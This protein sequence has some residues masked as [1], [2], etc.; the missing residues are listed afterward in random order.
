[1]EYY[2]HSKNESGVR[3]LLADHLRAVAELTAEFAKPLG[4]EQAGYYLGLWHDIGKFDPEWQRYLLDCEA[5]PERKGHGPDHKFAG[6]RLAMDAELPP[7]ALLIAGHHGGLRTRVDMDTGLR[8]KGALPGATAARGLAEEVLAELVPSQAPTFPALRD[9]LSAEFFM[10]FLYSA[11]VDADSLDTEGHGSP[12]RSA[13]R[14]SR[15]SLADLWRRFEGN[16][17]AMLERAHETPVN[18]VRREVYEACVQAA[19]GGPGT[20]SLSVPTGGGKT[21]AGMGF[22]LRHALEN[23]QKRVIVAVPYLS[24]TEQTVDEYRKIFEDEGGPDPVV[25]EHHSAVRPGGDDEDF[26][27]TETWRRLAAENWDA[28]IVVTTTVQLFES[29]FANRRTPTRKLHRLANSVVILDEAQALPVGLLTPILDALKQLGTH[30]TTTVI[31]TATQPAFS[32]LPVFSGVGVTEIVPRSERYFETLKRV[33]YDWRD[34]PLTWEQTAELMMRSSQAL[35]VVNTRKDALALLDALGDEDALYLSTHLCGAHRRNVIAEIRRRLRDEEACRLVSTQVIE[36]GVDLD[37]PLVLRAMAPLD[38]I[39]QAA[40]RCNREGLLTDL[41]GNPTRGQVIVFVPV[42]GG[43]PPS[44][45]YKT[46]TGRTAAMQAEGG[47]DPNSPASVRTYFERLYDVV[48]TDSKKV[49]EARVAMNYPETARRFRMI[50]EDTEAVVITEYGT[51][52]EQWDV[53]R[54]LNRLRTG[55]RSARLLV[56]QLQPYM[57]SVRRNQAE[58]FRRQGL[59]ASVMEGLGEWTGKYDPAC[60]IARGGGAVMVV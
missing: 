38:S 1:M 17:K 4:A 7:I 25:L 41:E 13:L 37:F 5:R 8:E 34:G 45:S 31:S 33:D 11:L 39:I 44:G 43:L 28:P 57:V 2:A 23:G 59:I 21:R 47:L 15:V 26:R 24:I 27:P 22:A 18:A 50:D 48:V 56:R 3:H 36:A 46:G 10:R 60:G 6:A 14:G 32:A 55:D 9:S 40:G 19:P 51:A 54:A 20:Y 49:Q 42:D 16:Q 52:D 35:A 29:L 30:G 58:A 53:V 12:D